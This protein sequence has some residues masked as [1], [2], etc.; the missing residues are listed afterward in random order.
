MTAIVIILI[1]LIGGPLAWL[2]DKY[3]GG[4][5]RWVALAALFLTLAW[6]LVFWAMAP[7]GWAATA[8][9]PW[10]VD[11]H[12][13]WIPRFGIGFHF[14]MDG[15]SL[16]LAVL[17]LFLG[18]VAVTASW[19]E[20]RDRAGFF[21][22]NLLW[23][24]GGVLGVLTALDLFLFFLFWELMLV[25]MYFLISL[26][27]HGKSSQAAIRFFIFT[28]GSG[29][30]LLV[31]IL[32]LVFGHQAAT[33]TLTF[34]YSLLRGSKLDPHVAM[35]AMLGFFL[36]FAVKLP[37]IPLHTW[38]P[39][40]ATLA[41]TGGSVILAAVLDKAPAYGLIR[42]LVPLFPDA[43]AH[44]APAAMALGVAGIIYGGVLAFA[45]SDIKRLV[46]YSS[47]SHMGFVL[48]GVFAWNTLALQGVVVQLVA[49][50][51]AAA[52]L[53]MVAG[54][55]RERLGTLDGGEMSGLWAQ[56]PRLSAMGLLFAM[57]TLGLPG[58]GNFVGE[59][60]ILVGTFRNYPALTLVAVVGMIT[61][62]VYALALVQRAFHGPPGQG[63]PVRDYGV[64]E[65]FAMA[66]MTVLI[67]W[68]GLYPQPLF[69]AA[70]PALAAL[71]PAMAPVGG[72]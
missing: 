21:Y 24:V 26:W 38:F 57:A 41:P 43:S 30:L 67:V 32:I 2:A 68:L 3:H 6:L 1:L 16:T 4:L 12:L 51:I 39:D 17:T 36:A 19:T 31:G 65:G 42:F 34:D 63:A 58:F 55:I 35:W 62:T 60:L 47:I 50:G 61:T 14:A 70:A 13:P 64:R 49:H 18:T 66:V 48:L 46:A 23:A 37:A 29:L 71:G 5:A 56:A 11:L 15:L 27:G 33:G 25:P 20:I 54:S 7:A 44:L 40:A 69:H 10:L 8:Q 45:Q 52:A 22:L 59:I 72:G 9:G 28:Q 53:F